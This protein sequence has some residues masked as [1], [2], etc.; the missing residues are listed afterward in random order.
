MVNVCLCLSLSVCVRVLERYEK[1]MKLWFNTASRYLRVGPV[2]RYFIALFCCGVFF[3]CV[4]LCC[5]VPFFFS[6][7]CFDSKYIYMREEE[8]KNCV[9][10]QQQLEIEQPHRV[11]ISF[12]FQ[13]TTTKK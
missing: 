8:E 7:I 6:K 2:T 10:K 13:I 1:L 11:Y 12:C 4:L 3:S 5:V 9:L